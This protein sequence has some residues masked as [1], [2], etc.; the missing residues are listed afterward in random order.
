M[1]LMKC[2]EMKIESGTEKGL[3]IVVRTGTGTKTEIG[4]RHDWIIT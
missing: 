3:N 1:L 4:P 2:L